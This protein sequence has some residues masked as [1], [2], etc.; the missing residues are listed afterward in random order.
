METKLTLKLE[1]KLIN[2]AKNLA[3]LKGISLSKMITDYLNSVVTIS[4]KENNSSPILME[5]TGILS[6]D[7]DKKH[8]LEDYKKHLEEKYFWNQYFVI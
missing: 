6:F 7:L 2:E 3:T 4:K 1:K 8:L 5:I